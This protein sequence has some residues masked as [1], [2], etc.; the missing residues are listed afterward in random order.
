MDLPSWGHWWTLGSTGWKCNPHLPEVCSFSKTA[1]CSDGQAE[2]GMSRML[3]TGP[4]PHPPVFEARGV[5]ALGLLLATEQL[6]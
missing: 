6:A 3:V 4:Y 2:V 5:R 1:L